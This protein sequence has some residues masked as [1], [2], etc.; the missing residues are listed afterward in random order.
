[1]RRIRSVLYLAALTTAI[2]AS[3]AQPSLAGGSWADC[4]RPPPTWYTAPR[5]TYTYSN[6]YS[7]GYGHASTHE[8][9]AQRRYSM[10]QA[11]R[12]HDRFTRW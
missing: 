5:V 2:S 12:Y 8:Y 6:N 4:H 3:F 11:R 9:S 1:M 7:S 10:S